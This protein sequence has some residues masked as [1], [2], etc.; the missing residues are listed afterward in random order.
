MRSI[1]PSTHSEHCAV[2]TIL[3]LPHKRYSFRFTE[4]STASHARGTSQRCRQIFQV[5]SAI[6]GVIR[7]CRGSDLLQGVKCFLGCA[8]RKKSQSN[9]PS[10]S[11][12]PTQN[13]SS[14]AKR[15]L[16]DTSLS[17]DEQ[18]RQRR[19]GSSPSAQP[20]QQHLQQPKLKRIRKHGA[21]LVCRSARVHACI[22]WRSRA[23]C[24]GAGVSF[25][26]GRAS[27]LWIHSREAMCGGPRQQN[28]L[29]GRARYVRR[30]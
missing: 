17:D 4:R 28:V 11:G 19:E 15:Q 14:G 1:S 16:Q 23:G 13:E 26:V 21:G 2:W 12:T 6:R 7:S 20:Q 25:T 22:C 8:G 24:T 30:T 3:I 27:H 9:N 5:W 18:E 29:Q 10:A